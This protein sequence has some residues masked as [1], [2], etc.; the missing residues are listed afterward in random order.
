MQAGDVPAAGAARPAADVGRPR[1]AQRGGLRRRRARASRVG[2][3]RGRRTGRPRLARDEGL[4]GT[5]RGDR[6]SGSA[7]AAAAARRCSTPATCSAPTRRAISTS[8]AAR[9]TSSRAAARRSAREEV[10]NVLYAIPSV[11]EAA[12]VGVPDAILGQAIKAFVALEPGVR[13]DRA[14]RAAPLRRAP[15][16]LHGAED[17]RIP[18]RAA[19]DRQRQD[20]QTRSSQGV[21]R[22]IRTA[23]V[24]SRLLADVLR[25]RRRTRRRERIAAAIREQVSGNCAARARSS[26][27]P[28]ASTA[29]SPPRCAS[30]PWARSRARAV[31]ARAR[32]APRQPRPGP[33]AGRQPGHRHRAGGHQPTR[34]TPPAATAAATRRSA[35]CFPSTARAAS[36][37][38]VLP[39]VLDGS[40]YRVFSVVVQSPDGQIAPQAAAAGGLSGRSWP[41]PTSS[42]AC[43]R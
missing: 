13:A 8:S 4:L 40:P 9:T 26:G 32:L 38:I 1:H 27:F 11:A 31:H 19:Q 7:R 35:A 23:T 33:A 10:E 5:A 12:V 30:G 17:R 21:R 24:P 25:A 16:R 3:R 36:S 18:R 2:P 29:A 41:P 42:S 39:D 15:G 20:R 34:S 43:A 22:M 6:A 28:A 37:K 14:G